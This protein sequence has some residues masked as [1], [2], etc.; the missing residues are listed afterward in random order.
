MA[1]YDTSKWEAVTPDYDTSKWEPVSI[2]KSGKMAKPPIESKKAA[3]PLSQTAGEKVSQFVGEHSGS[4]ALGRIVGAGVSKAIDDPSQPLIGA[5]TGSYLQGAS[6]LGRET[7]TLA[8]PYIGKEPSR[9]AGAAVSGA[10]M[11]PVSPIG[12]LASAGY[13]IASAA[14]EDIVGHFT[15]NPYYKAAAG[16]VAPFLAGAGARGL[17]GAGDIAGGATEASEE[18]TQGN[19]KEA[20]RFAKDTAAR[21]VED[22]KVVSKATDAA[23]TAREQTLKQN[24]AAYNAR[25]QLTQRTTEELAPQA[26]QAAI[27]NAT[28]RSAAQSQAEVTMLR[29]PER[30]ARDEQFRENTIAP[31][32]RWR[33]EW[34][35]RRNAVLEPIK[36][37]RTS[38]GELVN[39]MEDTRVE[40]GKGG[41]I[42]GAIKSLYKRAHLVAGSPEGMR[43]FGGEGLTEE[44]LAGMKEEDQNYYRKL[45]EDSGI[46][47][48]EKAKVSDLLKLQ[49]DAQ[50]VARASKGV[51]RRQAMSI[52]R[53]VDDTLAE[54]DPSKELGTHSPIVKALKSLNSE[55]RDHRKNF[56]YKFEDAVSTAARPIDAA[57][58]IFNEPQRALDLY[59]DGTPE[60]QNAMKR[61]YADAVHDSGG[62]FIDKD[63][64]AFLQ[65]AF[66]G[67][68]LEKPNSWVTLPDKEVRTS[69]VLTSSPEVQNQYFKKIDAAIAAEAEKY[70][71]KDPQ[72]A[73]QRA[74][75]MSLIEAPEQTAVTPPEFT[76]TRDAALKALQEGRLA[77]GSSTNLSSLKQRF[78][79]YGAVSL[80]L[81]VGMGRVSPGIAGLGAF[82]G[83]E[84][85]RM[86]LQRAFQYALSQSPKMAENFYQAMVKPAAS[87]SQSIIARGIA[88]AAISDVTGRMAD[89][90]PTPSDVI[91]APA[92]K[93][94][95]TEVRVGRPGESHADIERRMPAGKTERGFVGKDGKFVSRKDAT[96]AFKAIGGAPDGPLHSDDA[97]TGA[98]P[99]P[100]PVSLGSTPMQQF[101]Q[102]ALAKAVPPPKQAALRDYDEAARLYRKGDVG[103]IN[104]K[105]WLAKGLTPQDLAEGWRRSKLGRVESA[106][107][108]LPLPAV[109]QAANLADNPKDASIA[110]RV[111]GSKLSRGGWQQLPPEQRAQLAPI[112]RRVLVP[113]K[114]ATV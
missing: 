96:D 105:E 20:K 10:A 2:P 69:D 108:Q 34:A 103:A 84:L 12:P 80:G 59:T 31:L 17:V 77:K 24:E 55:Y 35:G 100:G 8:E 1:D 48:S 99:I 78:M 30:I 54:V 23:D 74:A 38:A 45:W 82:T 90:A 104:P 81:G 85:A 18:A 39:A 75:I 41:I 76:E 72:Q 16:F 113:E 63:H 43:L 91:N 106:L 88:A 86:G 83:A 98:P 3:P 21:D 33:Q 14:G 89:P 79:R 71:T 57:K 61:L 9:L 13:G 40:A 73:A 66:K 32:Q 93:G 107:Q 92:V 6:E 94:G 53:G 111:L 7:Q 27:E 62:K 4:P 19:V 65:R 25:T 28:G 87:I 29:S 52:V 101:A 56:P 47:G 42:S 70:S 44:D 68:V 97:T 37:V 50:G 58:D 109:A 95:P 112:L 5:V 64:A 26:K 46:A 11:A 36:D 114:E 67:T 110:R 102:Q 22:T 49:S 60:E 51:A 15:D